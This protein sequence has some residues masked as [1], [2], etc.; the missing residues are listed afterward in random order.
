MT[1]NKVQL[2]SIESRKYSKTGCFLWGDLRGRA[3]KYIRLEIIVQVKVI[4]PGGQN[5]EGDGRA[6]IGRFVSYDVFLYEIE[7]LSFYMKLQYVG[8]SWKR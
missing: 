8:E 4:Q 7:R 1:H 2:S 5:L 3:L 6:H